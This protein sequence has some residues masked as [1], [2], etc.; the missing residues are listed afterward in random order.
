MKCL[1]YHKKVL[2]KLQVNK[3][4]NICDYK[5]GLEDYLMIIV[6]DLIHFFL[7]IQILI[8]IKEK[9]FNQQLAFRNNKEKVY[10]ILDPQMI[11]D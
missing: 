6:T 8:I 9:I 1:C 10:F 11:C 3:Y 4:R 2:Q 7:I 5:L